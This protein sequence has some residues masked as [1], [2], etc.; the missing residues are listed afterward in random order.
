MVET[1][2]TLMSI[3]TDVFIDESQSQSHSQS[4]SMVI[5]TEIA[6]VTTTTKTTKTRKPRAKK[7]DVE[8]RPGDY[9]PRESKGWKIG[10]HISAA[11]G[12]EAAIANAAKIGYARY[13]PYL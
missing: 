1:Q 12:V 8:P 3:G 11:G 13:P 4:Q 2:D 6:T 9:P 10:A 5:E 7:A